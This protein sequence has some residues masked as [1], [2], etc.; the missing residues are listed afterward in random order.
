[1]GRDQLHGR[2]GLEGTK[3]ILKAEKDMAKTTHTISIKEREKRDMTKGMER[4]II[5]MVNAASAE[6]GDTKEANVGLLPRR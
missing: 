4:E 6:N 2:K 3:D 1:M 5:L